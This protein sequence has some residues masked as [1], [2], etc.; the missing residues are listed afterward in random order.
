[1]NN[2]TVTCLNIAE[3]TC[4]NYPITGIFGAIF[5]E[6]G[7]MAFLALFIS[8]IYFFIRYIYHNCFSKHIK[9]KK[10]K[11]RKGE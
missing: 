6:V 2:I 5:T 9:K 8:L 7:V 1:M 10:I 3:N 4:K 11:K